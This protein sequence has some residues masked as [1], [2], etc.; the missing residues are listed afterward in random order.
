MRITG[1]KIMNL[2][3]KYHGDREYGFITGFITKFFEPLRSTTK[4]S[5][6]ECF[7]IL[8]SNSAGVIDGKVSIPKYQLSMIA[9]K[10]KN[11]DTYTKLLYCINGYYTQ[12]DEL[13]EA[14]VKLFE[15][16]SNSNEMPKNLSEMI[17]EKFKNNQ[18]CE[19]ILLMFL[20]SLYHKENIELL[21]FIYNDRFTD[22]IH[23]IPRMIPANPIYI[24]HEAFINS[25][26]DKLHQGS[27]YVFI[28]GMGGIGKTETSKQYA[29]RFSNEYDTVVFA[30]FNSSIMALFND[31]T[32][33]TLTQP[34]DS[35]LRSQETAEDYYKR[36]LAAFR[37]VVVNQRTLIILDNVDVED[38][39]L[40]DFLTG[41]CHV[42]V[43][44]RL[45]TTKMYSDSETISLEVMPDIEECKKIFS[46]YYGKDISNDP[47]VVEIIKHFSG[48]I[49]ALEL[50]A[51]QMRASEL[52]A[53]EMWKLLSE[54]AE[55]ELEEGILIPNNSRQ[56]K[57]MAQHIQQ[58]FNIAHLSEKQ[59]YILSCMA[60]LPKKGLAR[61]HV[62]D[63]CGLKSFKEL[64]SLVSRSWLRNI[65]GTITIHSLIKESVQIFARPTLEKMLTFICPMIK[66]L[67]VNPESDV[68]ALLAQE[69]ADYIYERNPIPNM[70][71]I[72]FYKLA[73][74][75]YARF[76]EREKY[77][78]LSNKVC[79]L[80]KNVL[81]ETDPKTVSELIKRGFD[82]ATPFS[83]H[84]L[85]ISTLYE[86]HNSLAKIK[87]IN[88]EDRIRLVFVN[89]I[90]IFFSICFYGD[91]FSMPKSKIHIDLPYIMK[92]LEQQVNG[93]T[94][95][96]EYI[97]ESI[98]SDQ[99]RSPA[100]N[101][102]LIFCKEILHYCKL[103]AIIKNGDLEKAETY[104]HTLGHDNNCDLH[105]PDIYFWLQIEL[106]ISQKQYEEVKERVSMKLY[107][108]PSDEIFKYT[109]YADLCAGYLENCF[110]EAFQK[111]FDALFPEDII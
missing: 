77:I 51:K 44:T 91:F 35:E 55:D 38:Q 97:I 6:K 39:M 37:Q 40:S 42:I 12:T 85:S 95:E 62:R 45:D 56:P 21:S 32:V 103:T 5:V 106:L 58:I 27:H 31:N 109:N 110:F 87:N 100:D 89:N 24:G 50:T 102:P 90:I 64:D 14:I 75:I 13:Q 7:P 84:D 47:F 20:W 8:N 83:S 3:M 15:E 96:T 81:G 53:E 111:Q 4:C 61:K 76:P 16:D 65:D 93:L 67:F 25:I 23:L 54:H 2:L 69:I 33:F 19:A 82:L 78:E 28:Q 101:I 70:N 86:V 66:R 60:M 41:F 18:N 72:E 9:E 29:K 11:T 68:D 92:D 73:E 48:H 26:H 52:S 105:Y 36:K 63:F 71:T 88:E 104:L 22:K 80:L 94:N 74:Y 99:N 98:L 34:F 1:R 46:A 49:L 107:G 79:E 10:I 108:I 59:Q 17:K 43:T 57:S 30:E